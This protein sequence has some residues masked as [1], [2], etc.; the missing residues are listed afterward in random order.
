MFVVTFQ[1]K[2]LGFMLHILLKDNWRNK[3]FSSVSYPLYAVTGRQCH[4][5]QCY[6]ISTLNSKDLGY[7]YYLMALLDHQ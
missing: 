3:T 5:K 1:D 7:K 2:Q 6:T 4:P